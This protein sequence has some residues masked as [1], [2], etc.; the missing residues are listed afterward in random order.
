[1]SENT[2]AKEGLKVG[3]KVRIKEYPK[4]SGV[5]VKMHTFYML[6]IYADVKLDKTNEIVGIKIEDL[7]DF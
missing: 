5:I 2:A 7:E 3:D 4:T 6:G 1:M